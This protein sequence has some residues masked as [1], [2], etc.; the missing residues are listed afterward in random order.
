M[1][2]YIIPN[3]ELNHVMLGSQGTVKK[4][5]PNCWA[6]YVRNVKIPLDSNVPI[7]LNAPLMRAI[8]STTFF[9]MDIKLLHRIKKET[10]ETLPIVL[11]MSPKVSGNGTILLTWERFY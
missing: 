2:W 5:F 9:F 7:S 6:L 10:H 8:Q 4:H 3:A 11:R 1:I